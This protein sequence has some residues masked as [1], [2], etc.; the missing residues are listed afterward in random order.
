M[1]KRAQSSSREFAQEVD[2][3]CTV[4]RVLLVVMK[5]VY[6]VQQ[7][8]QFKVNKGYKKSKLENAATKISKNC[9]VTNVTLKINYSQLFIAF[10]DLNKFSKLAI[11]REKSS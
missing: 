1:K 6:C 9:A 4:Q 8:C 10:L 11:K 2:K 7:S 3:Y 5:T